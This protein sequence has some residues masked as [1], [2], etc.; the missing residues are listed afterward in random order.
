MTDPKRR[1]VDRLPKGHAVAL[2]ALLVLVLYPAFRP[3]DTYYQTVLCI[4]FLLGVQAVSW[5]IISG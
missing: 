4:T 3:Y 1:L 2:L 5:N